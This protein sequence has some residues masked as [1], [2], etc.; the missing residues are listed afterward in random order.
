MTAKAFSLEK[1]VFS[2][3]WEILFLSAP[4]CAEPGSF[5]K[6][7]ITFGKGWI[8]Q[9]ENGNHQQTSF[10][11]A[12]R[13]LASKPHQTHSPVNCYRTN[14]R[15][16]QFPQYRQFVKLGNHHMDQLQIGGLG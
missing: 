14:N 5:W 2:S 9:L 10:A 8:R 16:Q 13:Q 3:L 4:L 1:T 11:A 6:L 7:S 15:R 12:S